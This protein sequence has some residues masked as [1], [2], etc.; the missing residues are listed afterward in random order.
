MIE[1][2]KEFYKIDNINS[3]NFYLYIYKIILY[4]NKLNDKK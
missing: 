2:I 1:I 3:L 4:K